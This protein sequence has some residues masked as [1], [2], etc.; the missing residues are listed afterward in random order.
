[1]PL[2]RFLLLLT[3]DQIPRSNISRRFKTD[4]LSRR[5]ARS[6]FDLF[7]TVKHIVDAKAHFRSL[8]Q[9]WADTGT[10]TGRLML[11]VLGGL[12]DVERD[13]MLYPD[14]SFEKGL[15]QS[16]KRFYVLQ[17]AVQ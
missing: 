5:L 7:G 10:G 1:M 2:F 14:D 4:M 15:S 13:L 9:P 3:R 12:A 6:T 11:A 8:A 16:E 17:R